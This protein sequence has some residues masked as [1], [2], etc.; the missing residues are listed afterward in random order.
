MISAS[1]RPW[2]RGEGPDAH[3]GARASGGSPAF[4]EGE[5]GLR[6]VAARQF[7]QQVERRDATLDLVTSGLD[8]RL[9]AHQRAEQDQHPGVDF[10]ARRGDLA[11]RG[12]QAAAGE[13][14]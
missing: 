2:C 14:S 7:P 9:D 5:F 8:R 3:R 6:E 1:G 13:R 11:R 10:G 12:A 4:D